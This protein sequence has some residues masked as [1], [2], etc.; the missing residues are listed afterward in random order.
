M[1]KIQLS[2][3][4]S[5]VV[6]L[7]GVCP[8][9]KAQWAVVD[10]GAIAQLIQQ[11]ETLKQQL[12]TAESQLSQAQAQYQSITGGRGMQNL[13][14]GTNRNYL[15][16]DWSQIVAAIN[17]TGN[18]LNPL[19]ANIQSSVRANAVLTP[20]QMATF[21]P[22]ERTQLQSARNSA[23]ILQAISQQA[24]ITTSSRFASLQQ[25]I[26]TI[27]TA[28]DEK[29][30]LD[31][32]ARIQAEQVM[33][34][35]ENTKLG[36]LY[37]AAQAQE[38]ARKQATREQSIADAGSL[39]DLPPLQLRWRSESHEVSARCTER[40]DVFR[41]RCHGRKRR[42]LC[43]GAGSGHAHGGVLRHPRAGATGDA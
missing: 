26:N 31:L 28:S 43:T 3:A 9:A 5:L 14:N 21:S 17:Q 36:I 35:N 29:S 34:Q 6:A 32:Q 16:S 20:Q 10:V 13:L 24:L 11:Y 25:L 1:P 7:L 42:R 30:I 2:I 40:A 22:A 19:A 8:Q 41:D 38:W 15:P 37:Q 27:G 23:A 33:L 12:T 39:R 4:L 18:G